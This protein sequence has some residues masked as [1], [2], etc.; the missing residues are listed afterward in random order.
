M[1]VWSWIRVKN[2]HLQV[3][4]K[5]IFNNILFY[6]GST[7]G[8]V[9]IF[10]IYEKEKESKWIKHLD[11]F[12]HTKEITSIFISNQLNALATASLDGYVNLYTFPNFHLIRAIKLSNGIPAD[13]VFL[14]NSPLPCVCIFSKYKKT[15]YVYTVNGK[16]IYQVSDEIEN[17]L[18]PQVFTDISF[19]DFLVIKFFLFF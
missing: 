11:L 9:S 12:D 16:K 13:Y 15:F 19:N 2:M 8:I 18:S 7:I 14:S 5:I 17:L 10:K 6:L 1:F 4:K 3:I